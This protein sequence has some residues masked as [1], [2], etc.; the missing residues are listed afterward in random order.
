MGLLSGL[1]TLPLAPVRGV[2]WLGRTLED[3][4][5]RKWSDPSAV[6]RQIAEADAA[7]DAGVLTAEE[8]DRIQDELVA[9]L[10][11]GAGRAGR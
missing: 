3:E 9:R 10:L 11:D 1:L 2:L 8:R 5:R 6:R 7:Y 4:A